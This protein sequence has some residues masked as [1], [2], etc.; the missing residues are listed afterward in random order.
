[1]SSNENEHWVK[2]NANV[3]AKS[4]R[5]PSLVVAEAEGIYL[6]DVQGRK[7]LDFT[8]GGQTSN[9]GHRPSEV[10]SAVKEQM[11]KTGLAS[12]GW[13]LNESRITL[14]EK[15]TK[16]MFGALRKGK[17]GFCN[18]GSDA[19][20]LS[21]RLAKQHSRK[22]LILCSF[23]CFHGQPS[24]GSLALNTTPHGRSYGVESVPGIMYMPY[25]Y[26]YRCLFDRE[27]P[28]CHFECL[29]F[30]RY[31]IETRVIPAEEVAA[32]F[33]EPVQVHGGVI[34]LPDGYLAALQKICKSEEI[35]LVID[36]VTTGFGR[37]GKMFA[38]EHWNVEA[39][40]LYLA[41]PIASGL[42]LGAVISNSE[43]MSLF[44]GGGTFSGNPIAC[45]ASLATI[46]TIIERNLLDNAERVGAY[47]IKRLSEL[48]ETHSII[49][50]VRGLGLLVGVELVEDKK[51]PAKRITN[52][53]I[54]RM[55]KAGLL[56]FPAGVYQNVLR[57]CPPL[58]CTEE[59]IER[60]IE[61]MKAAFR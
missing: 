26:C 43:I 20:E 36:E 44:R 1:M 37:T 38:I 23:G 19:T 57:L 7:Y 51:Q 5:F 53:I 32:F 35:L 15:L 54:H 56:I 55:A 61:I 3:C 24:L 8:S 17:V 59:D 27:Y 9:I 2:R 46:R 31:Q 13:M 34:P 29:D 18:T 33:L 42:S 47:L 40:I 48:S 28:G 21:M 22:S 39:D 41:K 45:A 16:L 50:D 49:G 14:G 60:A 12:L 58:I 11:D 30:I 6:R 10:I 4:Y 52:E 25:P